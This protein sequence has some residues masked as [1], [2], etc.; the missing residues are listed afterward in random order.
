MQNNVTYVSS[1]GNTWKK[2]KLNNVIESLNC[3]VS[4]TTNDKTVQDYGTLSYTGKLYKGLHIQGDKKPKTAGTPVIYNGI[5]LGKIDGNGTLIVQNVTNTSSVPHEHNGWT[6]ICYGLY[7]YQCCKYSSTTCTGE[8]F[9]T[10]VDYCSETC[11][12]T[13]CCWYNDWTTWCGFPAGREFCEYLGLREFEC[14]PFIYMYYFPSVIE[15]STYH[16]PRR[17]AYQVDENLWILNYFGGKINR[18]CSH[19]Y[20]RRTSD[21]TGIVDYCYRIDACSLFFKICDGNQC[22]FKYE[23]FINFDTCRCACC[24]GC[25]YEGSYDICPNVPTVS[26]T[27]PSYNMAEVRSPFAPIGATETHCMGSMCIDI[28]PNPGC[29]WICED[30][31]YIYTCDRNAI[32]W[33]EEKKGE[34]KEVVCRPKL[35]CECPN[36]R[37]RETGC[38]WSDPAAIV[39]NEDY[40]R[41]V[42]N[43]L[44]FYRTH[45][46]I[47]STFVNDCCQYVRFCKSSRCYDWL[48]ITDITS[49]AITEC[50]HLNLRYY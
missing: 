35:W 30:N 34:E 48:Q 32:C 14:F 11:K 7:N 46:Y 4:N 29:T 23:W 49:D 6:N 50:V 26:F 31:G 43:S 47:N 25:D 27:V 13:N 45:C 42:A 37:D 12:V 8:Q 2:T 16:Y 1:V 40:R 41:S 39:L 9:C 20:L 10:W 36:T 38:A 33:V 44:F 24:C 3:F 22:K 5:P 18:A 21:T 19:Y 28:R 15:S 17:F